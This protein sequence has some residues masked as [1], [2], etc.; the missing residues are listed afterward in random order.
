MV[1]ENQPSLFIADS[2]TETVEWM[3][4]LEGAMHAAVKATAGVHEVRPK[5]LFYKL[6]VKNRNFK[7]CDNTKM[8]RFL[9]R[10]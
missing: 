7:V 6:I 4:A 1:I 5:K 8:K 3:S 10:F 2:E 9:H